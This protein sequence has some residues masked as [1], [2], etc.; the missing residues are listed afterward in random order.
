MSYE[1]VF[2]FVYYS[3]LVDFGYGCF[4]GFL[5]SHPNELYHQEAFRKSGVKPR[6]AM[7]LFSYRH[8]SL[9]PVVERKFGIWKA[10]FNIFENMPLYPIVNQQL[11][12]V[13]YCAVHNFIRKD[14]GQTDQL[15]KEALQQMYGQD[16][17]NVSLHNN[18]LR[19]QYVEPGVQ[20]DQTKTSKEYMVAY[21]TTVAKHMW[22]TVN[23]R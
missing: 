9:R 12:V 16:C 3:Y 23:S 18:M 22:S 21:R 2:S 10:R 11:F 8:F 1:N 14:E 4:R 17:V 15:F 5:P 19:T 13:V 20:L 6:N 7:E